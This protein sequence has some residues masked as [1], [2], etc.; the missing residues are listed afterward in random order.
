[1]IERESLADDTIYG[2][3]ESFAVRQFAIV[4]P[5]GLLVQVAKQMERLNAHIRAI[6]AAFQ[7]APEI[8]EAV[9]VN[10]A[11]D[12]LDGVIYDLMSIVASQSFV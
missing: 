12:V 7:Q 8:F 2:N 9:S 11:I 3:T 6:N 4:V 5:E 10:L 1:L